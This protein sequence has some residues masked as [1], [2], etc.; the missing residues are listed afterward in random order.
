MAMQ[1]GEVL[2]TLGD[3]FDGLARAY[4][5]ESLWVFGSCAR[6]E[7]REDSDIDILIDFEPG[8]LA[9]LFTLAAIHLE[10]EERLGRRVDLVTRGGLRPRVRERVLGEAMRVA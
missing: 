7:L 4:R 8:A 2:R 6:D 1:R 10:L 5:V 9:S 3:V